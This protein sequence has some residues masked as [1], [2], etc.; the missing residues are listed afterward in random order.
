MSCS[1]EGDFSHLSCTAELC[2]TMT[3]SCPSSSGS[4]SRWSSEGFQ[5]HKE[6]LSRALESFSL[7]WIVHDCRMYRMNCIPEKG[8]FQKRGEFLCTDYFVCIEKKI[9]IPWLLFFN[10]HEMLSNTQ[11]IFTSG[12]NNVKNNSSSSSSCMQFGVVQEGK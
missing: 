8:I 4:N 12:R 5:R 6:A 3:P 10:V 11:S 9:H 1:L 2:H 7:L